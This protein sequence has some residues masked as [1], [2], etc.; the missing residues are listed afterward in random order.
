MWESKGIYKRNK[1]KTRETWNTTVSKILQK[2]VDVGR[3]TKSIT[4]IMREGVRQHFIK[5]EDEKW[6][7]THQHGWKVLADMKPN[8]PF[9]FQQK[10]F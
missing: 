6:I 4:A 3:Y 10:P 8:I 2:K 1:M 7:N 9:A 5:R